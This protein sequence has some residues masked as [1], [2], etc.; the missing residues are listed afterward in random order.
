[1]KEIDSFKQIFNLLPLES[2]TTI[3]LDETRGKAKIRHLNIQGNGISLFCL[4]EGCSDRVG[5]LFKKS[6]QCTRNA[7]GILLFETANG[8]HILLC[9][10][11]SSGGGVFDSAYQQAFSSYM[12][13]CML[14]SVCSDFDITHYHV[15]FI[16]TAQD[17][18]ELAMLKKELGE[19]AETDRNFYEKVRYDLLCGKRVKFM[20]NA[21]PNNVSFLHSNFTNKEVC[22]QLL[23]SE[24]DTID[25]DV[26]AL[27]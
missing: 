26:K 24:A 2:T 1:M 19:I 20:M 17:G 18:A 21:I 10:L 12:K 11:K 7:D 23:V 22:C 16:F 15:S 4:G 14:M 27:V 25:V 8:S 9:E 5:S 6:S 3:N 13:L